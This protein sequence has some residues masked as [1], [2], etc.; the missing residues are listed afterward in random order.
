M[1]R[2]AEYVIK[3][4]PPTPS[5]VRPAN[6]GPLY[7]LKLDMIE[8]KKKLKKEL[9][10]IPAWSLKKPD[11][12]EM[13][14]PSPNLAKSINNQVKSPKDAN[15]A[16]VVKPTPTRKETPIKPAEVRLP[17]PKSETPE[18][19]EEEEE[20]AE[21]SEEEAE[22][23]EE[24]AEGSEE[25]SGSEEEESSAGSEEES[26]PTKVHPELEVSEEEAAGV[27]GAVA[28]AKKQNELEQKLSREEK[29]KL[30]YTENLTPEEEEK[31]KKETLV[32]KHKLLRLR[33]QQKYDKTKDPGIKEKLDKMLN[34]SMDDSMEMIKTAYDNDIFELTV[35]ANT[36][37]YKEVLCIGFA[38]VE[39]LG[40]MVDDDM[41]DYTSFQLGNIDLYEEILM[42][43]GEE[44]GGILDN[45]SPMKKLAWT[46]GT[47]TL[48]FIVAKKTGSESAAVNV[49]SLL[50]G[51][52]PTIKKAP[53]IK[54]D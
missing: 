28:A 7:N 27:A 8:N 25:A 48:T 11:P 39:W 49:L 47:T 42:E 26:E 32:R 15:S 38:G 40:R 5:I 45:M 33:L 3:F 10:P 13:V 54:L 37:R 9:P 35:I 12:R 2:P 20:E 16:A 36:Q 52:K 21:E 6:F 19:S 43:L 30:G 18:A 29:L 24:E 1:S 22:G 31:R 46:I 53:N 44:R 34:L 51:H 14:K 50:T 4:I 41:K 23:S 17:P